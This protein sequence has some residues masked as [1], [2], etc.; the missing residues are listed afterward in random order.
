[1]TDLLILLADHSRYGKGL[2]FLLPGI[3]AEF[4]LTPLMPYGDGEAYGYTDKG[5]AAN[6]VIYSVGF[7]IVFLLYP[8]LK[9]YYGE[10]RE[11][12]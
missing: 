12:E 7:Y 6:V 3:M 1:M 11:R 5:W 10:I 8:Q 4:I 9:W 2:F